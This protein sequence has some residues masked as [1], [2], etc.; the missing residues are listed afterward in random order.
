[1]MEVSTLGLDLAKK[2]FQV[3]GV[4]Q[5]GKVV[6]RPAL[7]RHRVLD[8]FASTS[9]KHSKRGEMSVP[10]EDPPLLRRRW[11]ESGDALLDHQKRLGARSQQ[12]S[13]T[14]PLPR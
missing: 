8:Y 12:Q 14:K 5:K 13:V 7:R 1:M 10:N 3:H 11:Q 6:V 9:E 4:D 2:V